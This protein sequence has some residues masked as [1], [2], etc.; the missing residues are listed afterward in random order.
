MQEITISTDSL[1]T[2]SAKLLYK[3]NLNEIP[4][5]ILLNSVRNE[6]LLIEI[7]ESILV[8]K[9][10]QLQQQFEEEFL[11]LDFFKSTEK[12]LKKPRKITALFDKLEWDQRIEQIFIVDLLGK[13]LYSK[14]IDRSYSS[15]DY[16][17]ET[18]SFLMSAKKVS[19]EIY[20]RELFNA[21][22]GGQTRI[23]TI[24]INF[25]NFALIMTGNT[26]HLSSF[27]VIQEISVQILNQLK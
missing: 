5:W 20:S 22:I 21:S 6:N 23:V 4:R 10:Y 13:I 7:R 15:I 27:Q 14:I 2:N 24:C 25:N 12:Y 1:I 11:R 17:P 26:K 16:I 8:I 18:I 9:Q 19:G 3:D